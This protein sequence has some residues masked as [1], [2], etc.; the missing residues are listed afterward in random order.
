MLCLNQ[1]KFPKLPFEIEVEVKLEDE[2]GAAGLVFHS[3]GKDKHYGFYPT[4]GSLRCFPTEFLIEDSTDC[5]DSNALVNPSA[6]EICGKRAN[7]L[8]YR[9]ID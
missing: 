4:N 1:N 8:I 2:S 6:V 5:D 9:R 3:D 7:A